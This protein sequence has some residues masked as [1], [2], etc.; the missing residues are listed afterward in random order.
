M[1]YNSG[2]VMSL[3][4]VANSNMMLEMMIVDDVLRGDQKSIQ[5]F[6]QSEA[7]KIL[8]EKQVLRKPTMMRLNKEDDKN[9]RIK[10]A[11]YALAKAAKDPDYKK[12]KMYI[13]GKKAMT[14][15]LM[16]KYGNK[17]ARVADIAQK[18]YIKVAAS[19]SSDTSAA[20]E[21]K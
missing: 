21:T 17:A 3:E 8:Q 1:L 14:A 13:K 10:L 7:C 18:N 20:T 5:E 16:K 6:C 11:V 4:E 2:N 15:K 19:T 9:R 12:L